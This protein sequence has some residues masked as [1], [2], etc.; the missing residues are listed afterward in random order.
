MCVASLVFVS[1]KENVNLQVQGIPALE[2]DLYRPKPQTASM[3]VW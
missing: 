3:A 2:Y 1:E